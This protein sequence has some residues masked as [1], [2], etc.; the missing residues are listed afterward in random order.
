[1]PPPRTNIITGSTG[2]TWYTIGSGL[3]EKA[4]LLFEGHPITAV[5]GAGGM[6]NPVRVSMTGMDVG[7]SYGPFLRAA[8]LG[9]LPF[10]EGLPQLRVVATLILNTLHVVARPDL[11]LATVADVVESGGGLRVGAGMPGSG[12]LFCFTTLLS[13]LGTTVE[14]WEKRGNV[15]RLSGTTQRFDDYKDGHLEVAVTFINDPSPQLTELMVSR[16]GRFLPVPSELRA[17]LVQ[18]MG[19]RELTVG[20]GSYPAQD[21]P[22]ETVAL[23]A[24]LF[25]VEGVEES[26]VYALTRA[27]Y[28]NQ[29]YMQKVHPGFNQWDPADLPHEVQVPFHPGAVRFYRERGLLEPSAS[30]SGEHRPQ[31]DGDRSR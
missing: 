10:R 7:I 26:I 1:V 2:S 4:N 29:P 20:P 30:P 23:P 15:L 12:D 17:K 6:S 24:I 16:R 18:K 5:P 27:L 13:E 21:Y 11:E 9:E 3:A 25:T 19:F 31:A 22:I 8:F 14:E 28:D